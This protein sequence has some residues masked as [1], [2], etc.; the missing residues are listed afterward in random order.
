MNA[1]ARRIENR[2]LLDQRE[3]ACADLVGVL[4]QWRSILGDEQV[5]VRAGDGLAHMAANR[6]LGPHH[7][8]ER[9]ARR[10]ATMVPA[11][12]LRAREGH[13]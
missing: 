5:L 3:Y 7:K 2:K 9:V 13:R 4:T 1:E 6:R 8:L 10:L 11:K 12:W